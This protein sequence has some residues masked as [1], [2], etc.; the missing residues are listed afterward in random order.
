MP[1]CAGPKPVC[2]AHWCKLDSAIAQILAYSL[3]SGQYP[4]NN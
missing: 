2:V 4:Y 1:V 3:V